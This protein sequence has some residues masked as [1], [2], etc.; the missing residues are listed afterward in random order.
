MNEG[1]IHL[2]KQIFVI[3]EVINESCHYIRIE[4]K[5]TIIIEG[6]MQLQVN[7]DVERI[8]QVMINF[9]NNAIKYAPESKIIKVYIEK[10]ND[11]AKVSVT[12]QGPGITADKLIHLFDRYYRVETHGIQG[13]GLG[14]GLYI[15]AEI[16]KKH[17]GLIGVNSE[18]GKGSTF[19]FTLPD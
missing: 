14:L 5:Y 9:V 6:D 1:Q 16:I 17:N 7:A 13:S 18:L 11:M 19:W 2:N 10:V 4:G 3:S 12:D 8:N 15:C